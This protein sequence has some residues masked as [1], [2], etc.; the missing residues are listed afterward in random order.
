MIQKIFEYSAIACFIILTI[1]ALTKKDW[2]IAGLNFA[3][4]LLYVFLYLRPFK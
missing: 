1:C 2:N 3:L 4:V